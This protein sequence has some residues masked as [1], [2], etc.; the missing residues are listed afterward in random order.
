MSKT[1]KTKEVVKDIK[2]HDATVNLGDRMKNIGIKTKETVNEKTNQAD[3][4]SPERYATDKVSEA[5]KSGTESAAVGTEKAVRKGAGKA[6]EKIKD[7][8]AEKK[9]KAN[10][11]NPTDDDPV[12]DVQ[13]DN[14]ALTADDKKPSSPK[15]EAAKP[16]TAITYASSITGSRW[17]DIP[18]TVS[19]EIY[20][21]VQEA[22]GNAVKHSGATTIAVQLTVAEGRLTLSVTD[23][24]TFHQGSKRG[25]GLDSIRRRAAAIGGKVTITHPDTG[26]TVVTLEN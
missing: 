3:N 16:K 18:D 10:S 4:V 21:I 1:N 20:R 8:I 11:A 5:K 26:G 7:K 6:K 14:K 25:V 23:N 15:E 24:G 22:V 12:K 17:E 19:L 9:A 2:A 13:S